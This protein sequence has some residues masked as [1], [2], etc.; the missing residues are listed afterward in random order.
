MK[1]KEEGKLL[2]NLPVCA[3]EFIRLVIGK[4]GYRREVR[5]EVMEELAGH[6]EDGLRDCGSEQEREEKAGKLISEFGD[7]K[8]LGVLMRRAKKRCRPWWRTA[9]VRAFQGAVVL[10]LCLVLYVVWFLTGEPKIT[11]N[12]IVELNRMV[13]PSADE[14]LNAA[15]LYNEAAEVF[16]KIPEEL[17]EVIRGDREPTADER[18]LVEEWLEGNAESFELAAA[19]SKKPYYWRTYANKQNTGEMLSVLLPNM[20]EFR[21]MARGL[22]TRVRFRAE[23]GRYREAFDDMEVCYRMGRHLKGGATVIEQLVGIAME[24]VAV[25]NLR[26]M[27]SAYSP[28]AETLGSFQERLEKM[29]AGES[30]AMNFEGEKLCLY[31]EIQRSFTEDRFGGGHLYIKRIGAVGR[32]LDADE[33]LIEVFLRKEHLIGAFHVL[34]THPNKA[35]TRETCEEFY[36]FIG[37]AAK[38]TPARLRAEGIEV[39]EKAM[40]IVKGNVLLQ[41][42]APALGKASRISHRQRVDAEATAAIIGILRYGKDKGAYPEN[43]EAPVSGGYLKEV[44]LDPFSDKPLVYRR[45]EDGFT[46]YSVSEDFEDDGGERYRD[47]RGRVRLWGETGDAVFW[48]V[49]KP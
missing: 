3:S 30:F 48:P 15:P 22:C 19:G 1:Q 46:L 35:E 49:I 32:S 37:A 38:K 2:E 4:M 33:D 26:G 45:T 23:Q 16:T 40:E 20:P 39:D 36:R 18:V 5:A 21:D 41:L 13:R 28:D 31:D 17:D 27:L 7:A 10:I 43:W 34:F 47:E 12:Y 6:F 14:G 25:K 42:L 29:T 9:M 24:A 8:L 11:T 44:P